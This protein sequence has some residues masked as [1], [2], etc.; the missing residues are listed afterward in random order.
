MTKYSWGV[1]AALVVSGIAASAQAAPLMPDYSALP[2]GWVT[3]RYDPNS[4]SNVGTYQGRDNV[5]GIGLTPAEGYNNRIGGFQNTFYN[6]QGRQHA[7]SG[8]AGSTLSADIY[9]PQDWSNP[10][11]G[12]R[13]TDMWGVMTDGSSVT[14][15]PIIGFTNYGG[16]PRLRL[17][18]DVNWV[19]LVL[20]VS[21]DTWTSLEIKYTGTAYEYLING[22]T[23]YTDLTINGSTGFSATIMQA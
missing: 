15:Y 20:P 14:D 1:V 7:I 12:S 13:R 6:T 10:L 4:F 17:W 5:L 9:T 22:S 19:D 2:A 21:Y 16:A 3:D 8:G 11:N 23:V 18:D